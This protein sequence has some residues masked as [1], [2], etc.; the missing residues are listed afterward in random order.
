MKLFKKIISKLF[1]KILPIFD[2][3]AYIHYFNNPLSNLPLA[4]LEKYN[5][6]LK[7]ADKNTYSI[8]GVDLLEKRNG[9]YINR[10]WLKSLAFI[11][12]VTIKESELN[13]AHGRVLYSVLREYLL[14]LKQENKTVNII[15]TGTARGF[16]VICMANALYDSK[17]EGSICTLD[18]LPHFKK[19]YWNCAMDWTTGKQ[20]RNELISDYDALIERYV[21]FIQGFTKITLPK[22]NFSRIN[23]AFLDGSH[24]YNDVLFEFNIINKRQKKGDIIIFDDHNEKKFPGIVKVVNQIANGL[25]YNIEI[26]KNKKT[27][28]DYVIAKKK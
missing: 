28:R 14:S 21:V 6:L 11:T 26:I 23:F 10:E 15:E 7:K 18:V 5:E 25:T 27:Y 4:N 3:L 20:S 24:S 13:Y 22:V 17:Y 16:S 19:M 1:E 2:R 8:P 9:Y 12:Q